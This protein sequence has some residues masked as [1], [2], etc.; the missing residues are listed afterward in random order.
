MLDDNDKINDSSVSVPSTTTTTKTKKKKT[1]IND[2]RKCLIEIE[3]LRYVQMERLKRS[4]NIDAL[5][6][7]IDITDPTIQQLLN[8]KVRAVVN[9]F[10]LQ[11][12]DIIT[13]KYGYDMNEFNQLLGKVKSNTLFRWRVR[14]LGEKK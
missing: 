8:P 14:N 9:A 5:P 10:P 3:R 13:K 1:T 12:E 6:I 4:L 2:F 7:G 11:V